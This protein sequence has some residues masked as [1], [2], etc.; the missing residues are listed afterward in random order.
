MAAG[1]PLTDGDRLPWLLSLRDLLLSLSSPDQV[2]VDGRAGRLK[3]LPSHL[4]VKLQLTASAEGRQ[5]QLPADHDGDETREAHGGE[6]R[7]G[8]A[9][10]MDMAISRKEN[11]TDGV[12]KALPGCVLACSALKPEYRDILRGRQVRNRCQAV[13]AQ[14]GQPGGEAH[15]KV[16]MEASCQRI[17]NTVTSDND[18]EAGGVVPVDPRQQQPQR[19][20]EEGAWQDPAS[21]SVQPSSGPAAASCFANESIAGCGTGSQLHVNSGSGSG[22][23]SGSG[24]GSSLLLRFVLLRV[25]RA[26]LQQRVAGRAAEG[27]HFMPASLVDSQLE[28]LRVGE[29]ERDVIEVDGTQEI[30]STVLQILQQLQSSHIS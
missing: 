20:E 1:R 26:V 25:P 29:E 4:E 23:G 7:Q 16:L 9:N 17:D 18:W 11:D 3:T 21:P 12:S 22:L 13:G 19:Q 10:E 8:G 15:G 24:S 27:C 2:K 6:R 28:L 14:E 5:Q 30:Q